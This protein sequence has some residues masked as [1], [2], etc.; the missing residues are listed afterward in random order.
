MK[1]K[2]PT[3]I[4]SEHRESVISVEEK[5]ISS[6]AAPLEERDNF[7]LLTRG[8][9]KLQKKL[10]NVSVQRRLKENIKFWKNELRTSYF[11]ENIINNVYIMSLIQFHHRF[12][13]Q[14][15]NLVYG[16]L[17]LYHKLLQNY[18][19]I[20]ASKNP[21]KSLTAV[22]PQQWLKAKNSV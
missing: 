13:L 2:F 18:W 4:S 20:T 8:T 6:M 5:G 14:A 19:K 10:K 9:G 22:T 21:N 15:I 11:V 17:S 16:T 7:N 12:M 3:K 1:D